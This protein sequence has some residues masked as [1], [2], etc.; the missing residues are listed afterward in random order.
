MER[1]YNEI[2]R[3][4]RLR[5]GW[6]Q[7]QLAEKL[8]FLE[9]NTVSRWERG[10]HYPQLYYR[11]ELAQIFEKTLEELGL[12]S[13]VDPRRMEM[14]LL[15]SPPE[16]EEIAHHMR[17]YFKKRFINVFSCTD[18]RKRGKV[19]WNDIPAETIRRF[20]VMVLIISP[21][22]RE[23]RRVREDLAKAEAYNIPVVGYWIAGHRWSDVLPVDQQ[24]I[25]AIDV[26]DV[27]HMQHP[28]E[29]V[30]SLDRLREK[31]RP[32]LPT[33][34]GQQEHLSLAMPRNPYKGLR[35]FETEDAYDFFGRDHL[36]DLVFEHLATILA[37]Q[38]EANPCVRLF[39]VIG[40]ICGPV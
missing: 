40:P 22:T 16:H 28:D 38:Q 26:V 36:V 31:L 24:V 33:S 4:E 2:L 7:E 34:E 32:F 21:S 3:D 25:R 17:E 13:D 19:N 1:F 20:R 30:V 39:A 9:K 23:S 35:A 11:R 10:E 12:D 18:E 5:H 29:L 15:S 6:T 27:R 8:N 14:I 37:T